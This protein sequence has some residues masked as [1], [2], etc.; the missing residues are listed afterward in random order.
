M[1]ETIGKLTREQQ[2]VLGIQN[3]PWSLWKSPHLCL[4]VLFG[5]QWIMTTS[6]NKTRKLLEF[7]MWC[8]F[9]FL[10]LNIT[11]WLHV[12]V[13]LKG[14]S[15]MNTWWSRE[16]TGLP[17]KTLRDFP[18]GSQI[19]PAIKSNSYLCWWKST[20]LCVNL[21]VR[22]AWRGNSDGESSF[23]HKSMVI[24]MVPCWNGM[25]WGRNTPF[26][27]IFGHTQIH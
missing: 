20:L 12:Y 21:Q 2:A 19:E 11:S 14:K 25:K 16:K 13:F 4:N 7:V 18:A 22:P 3:A 27:S 5:Q 15:G 1:G 24:I 17:G 26:S 9:C 10:W 8:C 6:W 23:L